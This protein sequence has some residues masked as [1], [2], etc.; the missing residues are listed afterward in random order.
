MARIEIDIVV[1]VTDVFKHSN[2]IHP[3]KRRRS[4]FSFNI[5][6]VLNPDVDAWMSELCVGQFDLGRR[7]RDPN[8]RHPVHIGKIIRHR[9]KSAT[10]VQHGHSRL[11]VE[12]VCDESHF[13]ALGVVD[14]CDTGVSIVR[15]RVL[16][17]R[18][19]HFGVQVIADIVV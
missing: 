9:T 2:R 12:F 18:P 11:E 8:H 10:N 7:Q 3:V 15:T 13:G 6:I 4:K 19:E 17:R 1:L 16:H 14:C 5:T